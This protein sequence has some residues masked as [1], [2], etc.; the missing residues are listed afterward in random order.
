MTSAGLVELT[1]DLLAQWTEAKLN[2]VSKWDVDSEHL[3]FQVWP[4]HDTQTPDLLPERRAT[5][6]FLDG[7]CV[8]GP[9]YYYLYGLL[10]RWIPCRKG[11]LWAAVLQVPAP[12]C[13]SLC[14]SLLLLP[15]L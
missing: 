15:V 13:S 14:C 5:A 2:L 11:P 7:F 8:T 3:P 1:G 6:C 4:W 9:G 12:L 10:E